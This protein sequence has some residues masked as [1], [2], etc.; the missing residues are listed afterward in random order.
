ML[1][2]TTTSTSLARLS[3]DLAIL[4]LPLP[5]PWPAW[6][7]AIPTTRPVITRQISDFIRCP[8]QAVRATSAEGLPRKGSFGALGSFGSFGTLVTTTAHNRTQLRTPN[9]PNFPSD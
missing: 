2:W 9:D 3:V 4:K 5:R 6:T 7:G 8:S 1:A